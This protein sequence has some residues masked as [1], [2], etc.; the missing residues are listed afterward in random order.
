MLVIHAVFPI[1]P[2]QRAK[3]IEM[4]R[5]IAEKS[6]AEAGV[7]EYRVAADVEDEQTLRFFERYED[8]AAFLDHTQTEHFEEFEGAIPELLAGEPTVMRFDVEEASEL[9]V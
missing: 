5:E 1:D 4:S 6:R 3:A 8:E 7:I 9:E 2:E